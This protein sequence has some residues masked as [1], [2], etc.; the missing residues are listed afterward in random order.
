M[1]EYEDQPFTVPD[2]SKQR[3]RILVIGVGGG[4]GNAL[5]HIIRSG[6]EGV[7]FI[8]ANTDARSLDANDASVKIVLGEKLT[9]GLGAGS[10]PDTGAAAAMESL[11]RIKEHVANVDMVFLTAGMGGGTGTGASPIIAEAAKELGALVVA[12]VTTPF[13]FEMKARFRIAKQGIENLKGK[14]DALL[15]VEN[16]RLLA[17]ADEKTKV[18]DAYR[19]ADEVL[20]QAV[21]GVTDLILKPGMIGV[22]FADIRTVM[23]DAGSAIMGIGHGDGENRAEM[24]AR[25]AIRSP[26]MSVSMKGA[27][28]ILFNVA[29]GSDITMFKMNKAANI[30]KDTADDDAMVIWGHAINEELNGSMRI[31]VIATGFA[32][33]TA[34]PS[35]PESQSSTSSS[36][37]KPG[38]ILRRTNRIPHS[39]PPLIDEND[40]LPAQEDDIFGPDVL[41]EP[42]DIIPAY[43]RKQLKGRRQ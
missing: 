16:D 7:E 35:R 36:H 4:G 13:S 23:R 34:T 27:K 1:L 18:I 42:R 25:A 31:T 38:D 10:D 40:E 17:L 39:S 30:I 26:L 14:V 5:N 37:F 33:E 2:F 41:K 19:L 11:E 3:E 21:Q 6:V 28:G 22:D 9:K 15:V 32:E 12:V 43:I 24:A 20:R 29:G 8:A